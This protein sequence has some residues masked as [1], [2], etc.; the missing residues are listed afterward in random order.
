MSNKGIIIGSITVVVLCVIAYF[1]YSLITGWDRENIDAATNQERRLC[2]E[3]TETLKGRIAMLEDEIKGFRG[4]RDYSDR[5]ENIFGKGSSA[6]SLAE[7]N[8]T[9]EDIENQVIAFFAYLD[10]KGYVEKNGLTGSAYNQYELMVNDLSSKI[11]IITGET[12]SLTNL[13]SNIAHFYRV[14]GKE[15]LFFV[16]DILKNEHDIS[17]HAMKL[18][19]TWYTYENDAAKRI[20]GRPSIKVLYDYAGFFLTTLGGRSYLFRRDSNIRILMTFYSVLIVDLAND[21]GLNSNGIDIRSAIRTSYNDIIEYMGLIDQNEYLTVLD[22]LK[23]KY[24]MP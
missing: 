11:P 23:A 15:R 7:R 2:Q 12:E 9:F 22:N 24:N 14:L 5:I 4:Q 17:E 1:C 20:K 8:M 16:S 18:F 19:Y 13:F 3:Q 21:K 6:L 10:E